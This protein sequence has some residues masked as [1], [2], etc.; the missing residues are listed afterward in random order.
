MNKT[1]I[2]MITATILA[3]P[4]SINAAELGNDVSL[5]DMYANEVTSQYNIEY[6]NTPARSVDVS[7]DDMYANEVTSQYD[8][9]HSK[10][11]GKGIEVTLDDMYYF[12]NIGII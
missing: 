7:L 8:T 10:R 9:E 1:H 6:K 11:P 4:F 3:A 2:T 12:D 5:D